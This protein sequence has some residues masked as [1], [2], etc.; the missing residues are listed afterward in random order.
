MAPPPLPPD[1][2]GGDA[3]SGAAGQMGWVNPS[4]QTVSHV[5]SPTAH[6][7]WGGWGPT[8]APAAAAKPENGSDPWDYAQAGAE[9]SKVPVQN[10]SST[11][12]V[13]GL[14]LRFFSLWIPQ[15]GFSP[16]DDSVVVG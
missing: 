3:G 5:A 15:A 1:Y 7:D 9:T 2:S 8:P 6:D 11:N 4:A 14:T 12:Q 16:L 10:T 13:I